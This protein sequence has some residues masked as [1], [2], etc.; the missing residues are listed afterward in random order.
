MIV[1]GQKKLPRE[2]KYNFILLY[3]KIKFLI[4]Q[5]WV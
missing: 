2:I 1:R 4:N 3:Y 5:F